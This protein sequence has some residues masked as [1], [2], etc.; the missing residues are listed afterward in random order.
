MQFGYIH[1]LLLLCILFAS[2]LPVEAAKPG[3]T[4]FGRVAS[5]DEYTGD[6]NQ[7]LD[8]AR[9][10]KSAYADGT[11]PPGYRAATMYEFYKYVGDTAINN[12]S[13]NEKTGQFMSRDE[14]GIFWDSNIGLAGSFLIN[15]SDGS[16]VLAF[17]G[18]EG[19][20]N[21]W[22]TNAVQFFGGVPEQ[23]TLAAEILQSVV[24]NTENEGQ[25]IN[26]VGHSLGGGLAAYST[27]ECDDIS[28][29]TT[30]TFNSAGLYPSNINT[31][32][33]A[34]ASRHI[35]NI[36]VDDDPVSGATGLLVGDT[37]V[38]DGNGIINNAIDDGIEGGIDAVGSGI[39]GTGIG[40]GAG[41]VGV[42]VAGVGIAHSIDTVISLLG[43]KSNNGNDQN[44][45]SYDDGNIDDS[46]EEDS[47]D[48][49]HPPQEGAG[50]EG[51]MVCYPEDEEVDDENNDDYYADDD[52]TVS[53]CDNT[54]GDDDNVVSVGGDDG[55]G[56]GSG[57]GIGDALVGAIAENFPIIY[58]SIPHYR[59]LWLFAGEDWIEVGASVVGQVKSVISDLINGGD[60]FSSMG[61]K[62]K[63]ELGV[64]DFKDLIRELSN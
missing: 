14:L 29:V 7:Q 56:N 45:I 6:R 43:A 10:A 44:S 23:Y 63:N 64:E 46:G 48:S 41:A 49:C 53:G 34:E 58:P 39:L 47:G 32:N 50:A 40:A 12:L 24:R 37:Y 55:D 51:D 18:S 57:S 13:Y 35:T 20:L 22:G 27:L 61:S 54:I 17:R 1:K 42:A 9:L 19:E 31:E 60:A 33:R 26:V 4:I 52:E 38:L 16:I 21:D 8:N 3:D 5:Y 2:V 11:I 25:Q 30:T 62:L 36:R 59:M 15:E 28:R